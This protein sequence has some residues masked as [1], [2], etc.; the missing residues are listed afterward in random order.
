MKIAVSTT[1]QNLRIKEAELPT[2]EHA[3]AIVKILGCGLCGSD[4]VKIKNKTGAQNIVHGHEIVGEIVEIKINNKSIPFKKGDI[5]VAG[6]HVPCYKCHYC[7]NK[8]YSMCSKFKQTNFIPGGFSE[9]IFLSEDHL[10][11][12][13]IK[14]PDNL[15]EIDAS[16]CE[17]VACCV[18][19][20]KRAEIKQE[21]K[22]I[23]IGLGSI[24]LLMGQVAKH[25]GAYVIGCDLIDER[26]QAA[27]NLGF[28]EN[29]KFETQEITSGYIISKCHHGIGTD[30]VFLTSGSKSSLDLAVKSVRSGGKIIIFSSISSPDAYIHN[31]EIYYRELSIIGCY[32]ASPEDLKDSIYMLEKGIIKTDNLT[33]V[34]DFDDINLAVEDTIKNKII[35]AYIKISQK[36]NDTSKEQYK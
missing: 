1:E 4:L 21:Y 16:F 27:Q 2:I 15:S 6:H 14:V 23:I 31:N 19:A 26:I 5:I 9:Y 24:G 22:V 28:D 25:Y 20:V 35:K 8:N 36:N 29:I 33:T 10:E 7:N 13:A 30:Q 32:S 34:Y 18:R 11:H 12:T 17:P 3:G